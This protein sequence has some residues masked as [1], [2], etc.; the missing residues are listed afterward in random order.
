LREAQDPLE[1]LLVFNN[2][3]DLSSEGRDVSLQLKVLIAQSEF[4]ADSSQVLQYPSA[5]YTSFRDDWWGSDDLPI[6]PYDS[7]HSE[8]QPIPY[9]HRAGAMVRM[10]G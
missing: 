2:W 4:G 10:L 9:L 7:D 5:Y 6:L 1:L 8:R 3:A